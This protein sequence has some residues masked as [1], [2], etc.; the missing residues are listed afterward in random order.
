M[1]KDDQLDTW[2]EWFLFDEGDQNIESHKHLKNKAERK[3]KSSKSTVIEY[4]FDNDLQSV[5]FNSP[6]FMLNKIN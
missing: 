1:F 3:L 4:Y 2:S 5:Y 6:I